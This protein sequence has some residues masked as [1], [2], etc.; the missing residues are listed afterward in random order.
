MSDRPDSE[1]PKIQP[2][3]LDVH[4]TSGRFIAV[5]GMNGSGTTSIARKIRRELE[6][7]GYDVLRARLPSEGVR[8]SAMYKV[9]D[10]QNQRDQINPLVFEVAYMADKLQA[11]YNLILPALE[12]GKI[13]VADRYLL[14]SLGA[15]L[16]RAPELG[17]V[18]N[19]ALYNRVWFRDLVEN[20][21]NPDLS[22]YLSVKAEVAVDRL[23]HRQNDRAFDIEV[24]A[25]Q[26]L[27]DE[28]LELA[29]VN[30]MHI[31]DTSEDNVNETYEKIRPHVDKALSW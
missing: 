29:R 13:V 5:E 3:H 17:A 15:L 11:S 27:M 25:Y 12:Q 31:F 19:D 10:R 30:G 8:K 23:M 4:G 14:S 9:F 22:I 6:A 2:F 18:V 24:N 21:I 20:M 1:P 16:I 28:G 7:A 26:N